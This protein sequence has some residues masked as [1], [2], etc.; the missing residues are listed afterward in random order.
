MTAGIT[1]PSCDAQANLIR[2]LYDAAGLDPLKTDYVEAHGT[3]T[4]AGDP[5]AEAIARSMTKDRPR[6]K[7]L[8]VGSVESDIGHLEGA[9]GLAAM[10]KTISPWRKV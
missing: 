4:A 1:Y 9:S 7:P 3:G 8:I 2:S 5:V 10:I 6:D